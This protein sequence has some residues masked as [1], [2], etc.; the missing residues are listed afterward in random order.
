ML[1]VLST[2]YFPLSRRAGCSVLPTT[3]AILTTPFHNTSLT[4]WTERHQFKA[5]NFS[6]PRPLKKFDV[7]Q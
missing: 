5:L 1:P 6:V 7:L 4:I 2:M 3:L